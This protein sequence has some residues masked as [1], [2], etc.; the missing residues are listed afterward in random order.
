MIQLSWIEEK[1]RYQNIKYNLWIFVN[2]QN[3]CLLWYMYIEFCLNSDVIL[4]VSVVW[5][6]IN[7]LN[8]S[9][10]W[11]KMYELI[12]IFELVCYCYSNNN[13]IVKS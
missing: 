5:S 13:Y 1:K 10:I 12:L 2:F 4:S 7:T 9:H 8:Y 11:R 3:L 6:S